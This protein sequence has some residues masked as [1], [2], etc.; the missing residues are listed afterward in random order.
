MMEEEPYKPPVVTT[1]VTETGAS[2]TIVYENIKDL[3]E[4]FFVKEED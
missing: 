4:D 2:T 3:E 1:I